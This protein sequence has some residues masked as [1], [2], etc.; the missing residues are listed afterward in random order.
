MLDAAAINADARS[1]APGWSWL[2]VVLGVRGAALE[3][4][5]KPAP[6]LYYR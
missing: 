5:V 1:P 3:C 4:G 2:E 6:Q